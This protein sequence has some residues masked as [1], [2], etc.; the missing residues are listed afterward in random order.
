M[1]S[2]RFK[3][4]FLTLNVLQFHRSSYGFMHI[5]DAVLVH[6]SLCT[7]VKRILAPVKIWFMNML[8]FFKHVHTFFI[9][10][11]VPGCI[12]HAVAQGFVQNFHSHRGF[13]HA[14]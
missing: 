14:E 7:F 11:L 4:M 9:G 1:Q 13:F 12:H 8:C 6:A 10:C 5:L 2:L 3:H